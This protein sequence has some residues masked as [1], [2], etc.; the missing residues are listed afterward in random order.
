MR[1]LESYN[2]DEG[3][4]ACGAHSFE[5]QT[6]QAPSVTCRACQRWL[7]GR[8]SHWAY[9]N[10]VDEKAREEATHYIAW[11]V[12]SSRSRGHCLQQIGEPINATGTVEFVTCAA[13][14]Y[15]L[16]SGWMKRDAPRFRCA[17]CAGETLSWLGTPKECG[18][19]KRVFLDVRDDKEFVASVHGV[20]DTVRDH[21]R[22]YQDRYGSSSVLAIDLD[23]VCGWLMT[24]INEEWQDED[25]VYTPAE[26]QLD[27]RIDGCTVRR[28][29]A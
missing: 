14:Q 20:V 26:Q 15:A 16:M 3:A 22:K 8:W 23:H 12:G 24:T 6:Q 1:H 11:G 25:R 10:Y 4:P 9:E 13:C 18:H 5:D 19:C 28:E 7:V 21:V 2:T 27:T 29:A 17:Y